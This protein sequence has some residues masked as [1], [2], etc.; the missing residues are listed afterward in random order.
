MHLNDA[1]SC[2]AV[3]NASTPDSE[4]GTVVPTLSTCK[5]SHQSNFDTSLTIGAI[6]E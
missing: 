6:R 5:A 1:H 2:T 4:S 3:I